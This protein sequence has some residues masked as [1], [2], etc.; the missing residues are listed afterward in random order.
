LPKKMDKPKRKRRLLLKIL[1]VKPTVNVLRRFNRQR[2]RYNR[3][4]RRAR[5]FKQTGI[6]RVNNGAMPR[7]K[8]H[9]KRSPACTTSSEWRILSLP[10]RCSP[11]SFTCPGCKTTYH[12]YAGFTRHLRDRYEGQKV[13]WSFLCEWRGEW[14]EARFENKSR[15]SRR[16]Q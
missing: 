13:A 6:Q 12:L 10:T 8:Q 9:L 4:R 16:H 15:G 2:R 14:C 3:Q 11:A 1:T 7:P 5:R